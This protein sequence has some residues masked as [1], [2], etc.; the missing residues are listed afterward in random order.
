LDLKTESDGVTKTH[1]FLG[2]FSRRALEDHLFN[3]RWQRAVTITRKYRYNFVITSA[4][5]KILIIVLVKL[6]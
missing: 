1:R 6:K 3:W 2:G 5:C 4:A